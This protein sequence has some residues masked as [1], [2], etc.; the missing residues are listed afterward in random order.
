MNLGI[1]LPSLEDHN[2]LKEADACINQAV[3]TGALSDASI[4]YDDIAYQPFNFSCGLFNSTELWN[5]NGVLITTSLMTCIKAKKIVNN[6]DI[7]YYYGLEEN[8]S[9]LSLIFLINNGIKFVAR[10]ESS[11]HDL[12]RKTGHNPVCISTNFTDLINNI[13]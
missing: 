9:P 12:F 4:F 13:G 5:F 6:I 10:S 7:F 3:K 2:L 11:A 8:I 1:Y